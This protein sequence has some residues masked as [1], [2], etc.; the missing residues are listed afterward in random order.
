MKICS[1][2]SQQPK[3]FPWEYYYNSKAHVKYIKELREAV[4]VAVDMDEIDTFYCGIEHSADL[5][6]AEAVLYQKKKK[7]HDIKLVCVVH[8]QNQSV[9]W[10]Q[11]DI[12][13]CNLIIK[14]ANEQQLISDTQIDEYLI[15][16][17]VQV[18]FVWDE[19]RSGELWN[20]I[21]YAI[22]QGKFTYFIRPNDIK[23]DTDEPNGK[24]K[25]Q[26]K[27]AEQSSKQSFFTQFAYT[28]L[29][30]ELIKEHPNPKLVFDT[31]IKN[32]PA[33]A[34]QIKILA[35]MVEINGSENF[36]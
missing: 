26:L 2:I 11:K 6:F 20:Q 18:I 36:N 19:K 27:E 4:E 5:D 7:Y 30:Q 22:E 10:Q 29:I 28:L 16:N 12:A 35:D 21:Q 31:F 15:D 8:N 24:L 13:R 9:A 1:F 23:A 25:R 17:A 32:H 3:D 33:F 14:K 34:R